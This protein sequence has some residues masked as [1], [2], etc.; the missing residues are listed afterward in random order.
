MTKIKTEDLDGQFKG[1]LKRNLV[2]LS[3]ALSREGQCPQFEDAHLVIH[4]LTGCFL[5]YGG[6]KKSS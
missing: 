3:L 6:N 5:P 4:S 2:N 1:G